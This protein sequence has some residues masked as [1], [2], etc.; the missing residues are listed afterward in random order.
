MSISHDVDVVIMGAGPA[1]S[2]AA[3]TAAKAGLSVMVVDKATF[4]RAKLC[5]AGI[6]PRSQTALAEIF[7]VEMPREITL[8]S[9][10]MGF[11]WDGAVLAEFDQPYE[12]KYTYRMDFDLW[13]LGLAREAGAE[14]REGTR[15][16]EILDDVSTLVLG[17]GE[18]VRY[19]V[20]IGADGVASP[21][22][23]H[24]FGKAFDTETI[25]FAYE[26]E[27]P[28]PCAD[29]TRMSIDFGVV[30]WGYGWN[31]PKRDSQTIGV[32]S[33][34]G[35]DQDLRAVMHRYLEHEGVDP[36]SV[37]I[38]GAHIPFGDYKEKPGRG[39]IL[40]VGDAAGFV[41]AITGEGI[42][43]AMESGAH[44]AQAAAQ[45]IAEDRPQRADRAYFARVAEI[46][47]DLA[48]V[49]QLRVIAYSSKTRGMFKEKLA[50]ST[51][52]RDALFE[53]V[54]G[55]AS[56]ADIEK[57]MAKHAMVKVASKLSVWPSILSRRAKG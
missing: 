29:D 52:L 47:A 1:G 40:L 3:V 39:N 56:Y 48:K 34:R 37:T 35:V 30:K 25:G 15:V 43:L 28:V 26:T 27:V 57:R 22:A 8:Q 12:F 7:G 33:I 32:V 10:K 49:R 23:R 36:E 6:T 13:L 2:A 50:T 18:R 9:T 24:L 31:F 51:R 19:Q 53:V 41:D 54:R 4:P 11:H 38:K 42:A 16:E 14:V 5:G 20:L 17:G 45:V 44:A 46:Q 21:V 55:D